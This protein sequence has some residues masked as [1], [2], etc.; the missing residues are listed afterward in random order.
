MQTVAMQTVKKK[1]DM[2]QSVQDCY[3]RPGFDLYMKQNSKLADLSQQYQEDESILKVIEDYKLIIN[4][5]M[6]LQL[7][8]E[9]AKL[10]YEMDEIQFDLFDKVHTDPENEE[11][12]KVLML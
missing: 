6:Q 8:N 3:P 12:E 4:S 9:I 2:L 5:K 7:V 11:P 10:Q 1:I